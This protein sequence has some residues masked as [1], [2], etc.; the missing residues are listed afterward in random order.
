[1]RIGIITIGRNEGDRLKV[2]LTAACARQDAVVVYVDSGS[3]DSSVQWA[4]SFGVHV[5]ALDLTTPFTAA[6]ARNE[7][8]ARLMQIDPTVDFIQFLDGDCELQPGWI[9]K[10]ITELGIKP[11]AAIVCGR[12][13]E[14]FPNASIYNKLCDMEWATPIG[15]AKSCGGDM[16]IRKEAFEQ[17]GG[18]NGDIIAGEEPEM[19]VR[20]RQAGWEIW[21][22]DAEMTRHDAAMS[23][24]GQ[25]WKRNVRAGHAFAEG[26]DRHGSPPELFNAK[27]VK[28]NRVWGALWFI[29][30]AW[31]LHFL[32]AAKIAHFRYWRHH[33]SFT[34]SQVYGMSTALGKL[35]QFLGQ[36]TFDTNKRDGKRAGIIEYKVVD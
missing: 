5:V 4:E 28:S 14:R 16:L 36:R 19:C 33:D 18:Y 20:L 23:R 17:V 34:A 11:R 1:M 25:W 12:R 10:A 32:L 2:C 13:R 24:F 35:P 27:Q 15:R 29:P 7:G 22:I 21:R 31:P 30:L 6:R 9:D 3:T 8:Y 26:F